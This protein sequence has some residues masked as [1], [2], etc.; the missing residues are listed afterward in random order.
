M[1]DELDLNELNEALQNIDNGEDERGGDETK[2]QRATTDNDTSGES[3]KTDSEKKK[4]DIDTV[5]QLISKMK[6]ES[7][8]K[9]QEEQEGQKNLKSKQPKQRKQRTP[10]QQRQ[11]E[12]LQRKRQQKREQEKKERQKEELLKEIDI[13]SIVNQKLQGILEQYEQQN[14]QPQSQQQEKPSNSREVYPYEHLNAKPPQRT[15]PPSLFNQLGMRQHTQQ[16]APASN[17]AVS[18]TQTKKEVNVF[19]FFKKA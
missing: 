5:Y 12:E 9:P 6:S 16:P 18:S 19:D 13:D 14:Q 7:H 8:T 4:V 2:Q 15:K 17:P 1:T 3:S 11:F 10:A